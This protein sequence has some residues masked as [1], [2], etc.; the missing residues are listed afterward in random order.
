MQILVLDKW[1]PQVP[2]FGPGAWR[3]GGRVGSWVS[4]RMYSEVK[5]GYSAKP[6]P[7]L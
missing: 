1:P 7:P 3:V 6:G 4:F 5:S 2:G